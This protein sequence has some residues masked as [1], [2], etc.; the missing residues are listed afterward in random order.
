LFATQG[1]LAGSFLVLLLFADLK[2]QGSIQRML[3]SGFNN[4]KVL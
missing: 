1:W 4:R 2:S 3:P